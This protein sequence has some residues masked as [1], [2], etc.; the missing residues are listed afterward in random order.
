[1]GIVLSNKGY[2]LEQQY[3]IPTESS[4]Q[5]LI[6]LWMPDPRKKE[7]MIYNNNLHHTKMLY[8]NQ[9]PIIRTSIQIA[10]NEKYKPKQQIN[11]T[12]RSA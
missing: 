9:M 4:E 6:S 3:Q 2:I 12:K 11:E 1:M 10:L 5:L 7:S 8:Q